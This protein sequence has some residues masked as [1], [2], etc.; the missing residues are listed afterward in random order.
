MKSHFLVLSPH[1]DDAVLSCADHILEWK[2]QGHEVTVATIFSAFGTDLHVPKYS[3]EYVK[4]SGFESLKKFSVWRLQE[5]KHAMQLLQ[6]KTLHLGYVDGGF[7]LRN[8]KPIYP[9]AEALF[10]GKISSFDSTLEKDIEHSLLQI[11]KKVDCVVVPLGVGRHADH[12]LVKKVAEKVRTSS[13]AKI[14]YYVDFPY[15]L[16]FK[17]WDLQLLLQFVTKSISIKR[18][19][20]KKKKSMNCY[21]SQIPLLFSKNPGYFEVVLR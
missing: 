21:T 9:T 4:L 1:L 13:K 14:M 15:A 3:K 16:K 12:L 17:N 10:S 7:R 6:I 18:M 8:Q 5:D 20:T 2:K 11:M 19:S